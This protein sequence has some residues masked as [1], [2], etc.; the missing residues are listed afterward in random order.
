MQKTLLPLPDV[1][2]A[3]DARRTCWVFAAVGLL[4]TCS[5][6]LAVSLTSGYHVVGE[7]LRDGAM[8]L[9][10]TGLGCP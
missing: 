10:T 7:V 6:F 3:I 8:A 4:V 9:I 5:A 2:H 1:H